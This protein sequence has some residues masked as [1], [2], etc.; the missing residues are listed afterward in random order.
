MTDNEISQWHSE[1]GVLILGYEMYRSIVLSK[2]EKN[3]VSKESLITADLVVCDEGHR[4]KQTRSQLKDAMCQFR[5]RRC[6][7]LTGTPIQN[8][9]REYFEMVKFV[10]PGSLGTAKDFRDNFEKQITNG[11]CRSSNLHEVKQMN[12]H[13]KVLHRMLDSYVQRFDENILKSSLPPKTDYVIYT[14][15]TK[16][17]AKMY[18]VFQKFRL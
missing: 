12:V 17:L 4:L 14:P 6:I 8:N 1:G 9:L 18:K 11:Q 10:K 16:L 7:I 5:T 15:L 13:S 3:N 2:H